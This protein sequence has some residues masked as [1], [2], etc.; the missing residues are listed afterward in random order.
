MK[1]WSLQI[2]FLII[3]WDISAP[4]VGIGPILHTECW[5]LGMCHVNCQLFVISGFLALSPVYEMFNKY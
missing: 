1:T 4:I 3:E 2:I 5:N